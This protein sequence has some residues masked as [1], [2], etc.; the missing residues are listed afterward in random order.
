MEW[1]G[2]EWNG[3]EWNGMEWNGMEWK[4]VKHSAIASCFYSFSRVLSTLVALQLDK[5]TRLVIYFLN[6]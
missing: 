1:N 6:H 4:L 2:M 3:M 5:I